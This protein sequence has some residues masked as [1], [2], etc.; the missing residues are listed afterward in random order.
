[1][2]RWKIRCRGFFTQWPWAFSEHTVFNLLLFVVNHISICFSMRHGASEIYGYPFMW[3]RLLC[4]AC[5]GRILLGPSLCLPPAATFAWQ[6]SINNIQHKKEQSST[7][8]WSFSKWSINLQRLLEDSFPHVLHLFGLLV[9]FLEARPALGRL[10]TGLTIVL[11][12]KL[13]L[14]YIIQTWYV[15][16]RYQGSC[17]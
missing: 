4:I 17:I 2:F 8:P 1:M 6:L 15:Q 10:P 16:T 11:F 9:I 12:Y 13:N 3:V 7:Q 14:S 5:I